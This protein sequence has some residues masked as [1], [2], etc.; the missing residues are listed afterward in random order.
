MWR[1]DIE[2]MYLVV[3]EIVR[4][5]HSKSIPVQDDGEILISMTTW[6]NSLLFVLWNTFNLFVLPCGY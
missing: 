4:S 2:H 6:K 3:V 1:R 5:F